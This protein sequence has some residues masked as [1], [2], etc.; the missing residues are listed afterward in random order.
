MAWRKKKS[1]D[2]TCKQFPSA[3]HLQSYVKFKQ[4]ET[5]ETRF[6]YEVS[7]VEVNKLHEFNI[8]IRFA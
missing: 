2:A 3:F 8:R 7:K 4:V 6:L 5:F 1:W